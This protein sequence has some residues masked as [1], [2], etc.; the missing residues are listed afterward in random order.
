MAERD[1][2]AVDIDQRPADHAALLLD[3]VGGAFIGKVQRYMNPQ[4]AVSADPQEI[5]MHNRRLERVTMHV[6]QH[7]SF[8]IPI[9][10]QGQHMRV[11]RLACL[12]HQVQDFQEI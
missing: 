3:A 12:M 8:N 2:G 9:D 1:A 5:D 11:E 6:A 7:G 10:F 4:L